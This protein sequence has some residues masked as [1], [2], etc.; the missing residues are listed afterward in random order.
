MR[1]ASNNERTGAA[2]TTHS[3]R[4][5]DGTA[6]DERRRGVWLPVLTVFL[7]ALLA[8]CVYLYEIRAIPFVEHPSVDARA[9]DAWAQRIA[10]GDWWGSEVFYQA[11]AYPYLLGTLYGLFGRNL[12][13]VHAVQMVMGALSCVLICLAGRWF[14]G[15]G[16]GVVGGFLLALYPPAIF[17]D[18]LIQKAGLGL[19]LATLLLYLLSRLQQSAEYLGAGSGLSGEGPRGLK[20]AARLR[21]RPAI[22]S[23]LCGMAT[24]LLA[25]TRE[26]AL[27]FVPLIPIWMLF[28][29][30]GS[31]YRRRVVCIAAFLSG[32][33]L[34]LLPVGLRNFDVGGTFALTT[35]QMGPNFYIGN[36]PE[37][38][39][40]YAPL[41]PGRAHPAYERRDAVEL[42]RRAL[43]RELS[44]G[45]VSRYW[46]GEGLR[47]VRE[48]PG[49]W[50]RLMARKWSLVWNHFEVP[51]AEDIYVYSD[52]SVLLRTLGWPLH[53]GVLVPLGVIGA[54]LSWRNRGNLWILYVLV[55]I[56]AGSVALFYVFGRYRFPLVPLLVLF[57]GSACVEVY[58]HGK[59]R[60][61]RTLAVATVAAAVVAGWANWSFLPE[62]YYRSISYSNLGAIC[63]RNGQPDEAE[64][65]L[66]RA[67]HMYPQSAPALRHLGT[68]RIEQGRPAEGHLLLGMAYGQLNDPGAAARHYR[69]AADA[70]PSLLEAHYNLA[71]ALAHLGRFD[72]AVDAM[73][74][75]LEIAQ[76]T[77]RTDVVERIHDRLERYRTQTQKTRTE[78]PK[79][80][81]PEPDH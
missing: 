68:L 51:D 55:L 42:A 18:G 48:Q 22:V 23:A 25:L 52:W 49:D 20:P 69:T 60:Q 63:A 47:F 12:W 79:P 75:C 28:H 19:F 5:S 66:T 64:R 32:A 17:F 8:R 45:E 21:R 43:G 1:N 6:H 50:L 13:L 53:F 37:A 4:E 7:V 9:Y 72:E 67:L 70:D 46:F 58:A 31:P 39:G 77:G 59:A 57:G 29:F 61:L 73:E 80:P 24:G 36:N 26:N 15:H 34:L 54:V 33:A 81:H 10:A 41:V 40:L 71:A 30:R 78:T 74:R 56:T 14:F 35:A 27:L 65:Y 11:P 38:D 16:A 44:A 62:A 2:D 3:V 76:T